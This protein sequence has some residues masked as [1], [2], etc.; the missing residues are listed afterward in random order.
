MMKRNPVLLIIA[1]F[2]GMLMFVACAGQKGP[3]EL[4]IKAAEEAINAAKVEAEK[5]VPDQMAELDNALAA[6]KDK[7]AKGEYGAV[8][9]EA[10]SLV[11]KAKGVL[12]AALAKKGELMKNWT[13]LSQGVPGML[14]AIQGKVDSLAKSV[15]LPAGLTAEKFEEVKTTF[16]S[17][18]DDWA[19]ALESFKA[20]NYAEAVS[21]AGT[22]K[23]KAVQTMQTLGITTADAGSKT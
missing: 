7:F 20:G 6:V 17:A 1:V 2:V 11:T 5:Y 9:P 16:M 23:E 22:V 18:K 4:A 13:D 19:K 14:E 3:A 15:K 21:V 10:Q 12:D 8:I